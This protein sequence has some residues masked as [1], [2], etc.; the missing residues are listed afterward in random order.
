VHHRSADAQVRQLL[1]YFCR[2]ALRTTASA[3]WRARSR[4]IA[5]RENFQRRRL[6]PH[7]DTRPTRNS[8]VQ[9][10]ATK[11]AK[12]S[13]IL[14]DIAVAKQVEQQFA[15]A[16]DS[17]AS[18]IRAGL[19]W[20]CAANSRPAVRRAGRYAAAGAVL[21]SFGSV[22]ALPAAIQTC[23]IEFVAA[24][25]TASGI[26]GR[27]VK[28]A[29]SKIG[30][31]G[32]DAVVHDVRR[33]VPQSIQRDAASVDVHED[34]VRRQIPRKV[35]VRVEEQGREEFDSAGAIPALTSR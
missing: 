12:L 21:E 6:E 30:R 22:P 17:A 5:L 34:A 7:A 25:R 9:G 19:A 32:R 27:E 4:T 29:G 8:E 1:E 28:L 35:D 3:L 13:N 18:K 23:A 31:R 15:A 26:R 33:C 11:P 14:T 16:A 2:I 24:L 10:A 20:I